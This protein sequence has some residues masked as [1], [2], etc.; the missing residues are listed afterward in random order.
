LPGDTDL[1]SK[2]Q[3]QFDAIVDEKMAGPK[4]ASG[5]DR[6][7]AVYRNLLIKGSQH[8]TFVH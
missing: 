6:L 3:A 8:S 7:L 1:T 5:Y 2:N 4:R